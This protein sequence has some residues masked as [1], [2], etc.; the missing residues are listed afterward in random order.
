[1]EVYKSIEA[2]G[3]LPRVFWNLHILIQ[4]NTLR[5][6]SEE[7]N[8]NNV[9]YGQRNNLEVGKSLFSIS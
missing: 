1:M 4:Q 8:L 5:H 3:I 7:S 6:M 2:D 9:L